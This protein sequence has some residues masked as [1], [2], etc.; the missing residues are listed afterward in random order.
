MLGKIVFI[1][2]NSF[3]LLSGLFSSIFGLACIIQD[4]ELPPRPKNEELG[5]R[6]GLCI[7]T[8][9]LDVNFTYRT[10]VVFGKLNTA[11]LDDS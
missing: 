10:S 2:L 1:V 6:Q 9:F 7:S 8:A 3:A 11:H 4:A 5:G